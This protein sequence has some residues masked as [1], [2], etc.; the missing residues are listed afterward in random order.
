MLVF[1]T[2]R[3]QQLPWHIFA[4]RFML[5]LLLLLLPPWAFFDFLARDS[6]WASERLKEWMNDAKQSPDWRASLP[7]SNPRALLHSLSIFLSGC[8]WKWAR[9]A[10]KG[11]KCGREEGAAIHEWVLH[12]SVRERETDREREHEHKLALST[13]TTLSLFITVSVTYVNAMCASVR[14]CEAWNMQ[15][16]WDSSVGAAGRSFSMGNA[17]ANNW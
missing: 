5:Y 3:R 7:T 11:V 14:V 1:S 4:L 2:P 17:R 9:A 13:W 15:N 8:A 16:Q 6:R 10:C 12:L